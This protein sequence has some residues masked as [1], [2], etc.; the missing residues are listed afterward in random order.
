VNKEL[1]ILPVIADYFP[2]LTMPSVKGER[3]EIVSRAGLKRSEVF[4]IP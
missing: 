3:A 2:L 1:H 4:H